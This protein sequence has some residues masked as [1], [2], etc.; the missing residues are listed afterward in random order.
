M[1]LDRS[2]RAEVGR[3]A[4]FY[5]RDAE[6]EI[7]RKAVNSLRAGQIGGGTMI[8]QGAPG[9]GKSAL[10]QECMEAVKCHSTPEDPWV[11]VSV[12]PGALYSLSAVVMCLI[13]AANQES[14]RLS[15]MAPDAV[16]RKLGKLLELGKN[17]YQEL[18]ERGFGGDSLS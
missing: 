12:E 7:F 8:F 1:W 13:D 18:S 3:E 17:L 10:M 2:D 6:Y 16:A 15:K 14:K 11:A 9:A 5:G 4:F